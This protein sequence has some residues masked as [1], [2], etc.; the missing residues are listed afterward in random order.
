[1]ATRQPTKAQL[2]GKIDQL[3]RIITQ[4]VTG[5]EPTAKLYLNLMA[6]EMGKFAL[7]ATV[8]QKGETIPLFN[9]NDK[10][11]LTVGDTLQIGLAL[12]DYLYPQPEK[13]SKRIFG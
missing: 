5:I 11:Y 9:W 1:L 7:T 4:I 10:V 2:E 13:K 3:E 8:Q 12:K 6:V